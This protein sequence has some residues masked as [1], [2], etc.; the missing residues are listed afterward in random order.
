MTGTDA[1]YDYV[2]VGGGTAGLVVAYRLAESGENSV[3][4]IEAGGFYEIEAGNISV[5]PGNCDYLTG[6]ASNTRNAN[7]LI[8]WGFLTTPQ[9][10]TANR[11]THYARGK[12]LGGRYAYRSADR[13]SSVANCI[14][15]A[16]HLT[17]W[18]TI[19]VQSVHLISGPRWSM[20]QAGRLMLFYLIL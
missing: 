6:F 13:R 10:P 12:T 9:A 8:D 7:P 14:L 3:A 18:S 20:I 11:T 17:L 4:V 19:E 1:E 2:I 16:L 5:I 15:K